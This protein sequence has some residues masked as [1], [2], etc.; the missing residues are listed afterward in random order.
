MSINPRAATVDDKQ[1]SGQ[2][3]VTAPPG[4]SWSGAA[5]AG[6]IEI[7]ERASG[8]GSGTVHYA[9]DRYRGNGTRTGTIVIAGLTFTVTQRGDRDDDD[10]DDDDD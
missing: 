8:T 2:I 1:Q 6:W 10:D 5:T 3:A 7:T 4:C 9:V